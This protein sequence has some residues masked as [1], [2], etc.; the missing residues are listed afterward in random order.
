MSVDRLVLLVAGAC[1]TVLTL[2][3]LV[4][5]SA[6]MGPVVVDFRGH[7]LHQGDVPVLGV[8]AIGVGVLAWGWR[9]A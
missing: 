8:W 5:P 3:L 1:L 9:R 6:A 4:V 2:M 7:G